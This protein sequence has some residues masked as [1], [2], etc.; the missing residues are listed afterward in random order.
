[1]VRSVPLSHASESEHRRQIAQRANQSLAP[2]SVVGMFGGGYS[3]APAGTLLLDGSAIE[4]ASAGTRVL[5][6]G[7]HG[8]E[9]VIFATVGGV[10]T[11]NYSGDSTL[12]FGAGQF[13]QLIYLKDAWY[14][15]GTAVLS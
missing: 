14:V 4:I 5:P 6:E 15:D 7:V 12:T 9:A 11:G 8:Q 2:G 10:I 1:M 13:A 3:E